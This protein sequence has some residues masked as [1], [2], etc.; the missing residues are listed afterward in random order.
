MESAMRSV[1][2]A[3]QRG[4]DTG[5]FQQAKDAALARL[6]AMDYRSLLEELQFRVGSP[7]V[8]RVAS[9]RLVNTQ[10]RINRLEPKRVAELC[11]RHTTMSEFDISILGP[12]SSDL[13]Q[14]IAAA[15]LS[16]TWARSAPNPYAS[17]RGSRTWIFDADE[18]KQ[19]NFEVIWP[20]GGTAAELRAA[21]AVCGVSQ[22]AK[23]LG[24]LNAAR[25]HNPTT[26]FT[27]HHQSLAEGDIEIVSV[28][29]VELG[30]LEAVLRELD[31]YFAR[32][33][34]RVDFAQLARL[35]IHQLQR[36]YW[37]SFAVPVR[38][39]RLLEERSASHAR[40]PIDSVDQL[41][42]V[43]RDRLLEWTRKLT[44]QRG[45]IIAEGPA[46]EI[47]PVLRLVHG[48]ESVVITR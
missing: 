18:S 20:S 35:G 45:T 41:G 13:A 47:E 39:L 26:Q 25:P 8:T 22:A 5:S 27:L 12:Q 38:T 19:A 6:S 42:P 43:S 24:N 7:F 4:C 33:M 46:R 2:D 44:L 32:L 40:Q 31:G 21:L 37:A 23:A 17:P 30:R 14:R 15:A 9:G 48:G 36:E 1:R 10:T 28:R 16:S 11:G 29:G 3:L 34:E